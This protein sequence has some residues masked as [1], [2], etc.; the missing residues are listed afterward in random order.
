MDVSNNITAIHTEATT[1]GMGKLS[2]R[3]HNFI[4]SVFESSQRAG[5]TGLSLKQQS[6]LAA[7][8][9]KLETTQGK[10]QWEVMA[11]RARPRMERYRSA[12]YAACW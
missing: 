10:H 8:A 1:Y 4:K 12:Y 11:E 6:W 3:E 7:I 5:F 9:R 2:I